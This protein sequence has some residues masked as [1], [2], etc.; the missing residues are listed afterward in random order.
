MKFTT[1]LIIVSL[2]LCLW[3]ITGCT[4]DEEKYPN[5]VYILAD[6]M[7]Y[8]DV[9]GLNPESKI[10]TPNLDLLAQ[11]GITF[12]DA[13]SG[14]AVCTPT[15]YGILT[16]R[17]CWRTPLKSSVLWPWDG[18]LIEAD[19]L[20]VGGFL[21]Q[22]GYTT[23]CIGKWHLGWDW[24]TL[25]G[26]EMNEDI[27]FGK[28]DREVRG[29]IANSIDFSGE[30][31]NGPVTRGFDYYFGDDVPNF[32]PY[33][34]IENNRTM[35]I[36]SLEKP[37]SMYGNPGI[38]VDGWK[39]E[40]V[41]PAL[42]R[43]VV[44][45]IKDEA[46]E[47]LFKRNRN[48][49]FFLYFPLTAPHTPIAPAADFQGKS[50]AGA[51]GDFV[52]QIDWTVKEI[53]EALDQIGQKQNTLVIFT[54]DN[55]S[56]GRSGENMVGEYN[57]VREFGHNPSY[58][59]RGTKTDTWEG[60]HRVPFIARWPGLISSG[61]TCSETICLTDLM[62]TCASIANKE[63]PDEAG[64]DS[65]SI[66]PLLKGTEYYGN[67][68]NATVHHSNNGNFAIRK[69]N[70]KLILC[71]GSGGISQPRNRNEDE[72]GRPPYQLYNID[73]DPGER[74]N[75][76][77]L[78]PGKVIELRQLLNEYIVIGR[79]TPGKIQNN[80]TEVSLFTRT[81][82]VNQKAPNASDD[83]NGSES[84]P[85]LTIQA[86]AE[87][88]GPGDTVLVR[89]GIY[90][91][92]IAPSF[93]GTKEL[94]VVYMAAPGEKVSIRGSEEVS[95]W[96]K[97]KPNVWK[98]ELDT[99]FFE[100]YN[101][102][103]INI[104][105]EWL[106]RGKEHH[107]GDVYLDGEA[108]LEKFSVDSLLSNPNTWY[109]DTELIVDERKIFP[110]AKIK[111]YAN[112]GGED[113]NSHLTEINARATAFFPEIS[114]LKYI[115]IDGFDIRH[116]APQW[117]DIYKLEQGAVGMRY[118][119]GWVIQNCT[120]AYSRNIGISM[121]VSDEV[122][123]PTKEEGGLLEGGSNIPDY[124]SIGH[125]II[126]NNTISRCGQ[127]GI[128]GCY[129]AVASLIEGNTISEINYRNEWFGT[130]QAAIKILFPIDVVI[131]NNRI[132]G[133]PGLRNGTK[134]IW[135]D[136][137]SQNTRVS[138]NMITDFEFKG[139]DGLKLEVNFG[140]VIVDN[141]IIIR[142]HV[143]EE[144][145][146]S[147]FAHNLF[148]DGSFTF[149]KSPERIVPYFKA[150]S[151]VRT[152][153]GGTSLENVTFYNNIF[154]GA[155]TKKLFRKAV[156]DTDIITD[157]NLFLKGS[158]LVC[159]MG[160]DNDSISIRIPFSGQALKRNYPLITSDLIGK[161]PFADM[162]MEHQDGSPLNITHD[163]QGKPIDSSN[164]KPGPFQNLV[165]GANNFV[166]SFDGKLPFLTTT[167]KKLDNIF[168][169]QN[170][171]WGFEN[172][173]KTALQK[174]DLMKAIGFDGL[175]G[176][177]YKDFFELKDALVF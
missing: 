31:K 37:D 72:A 154:T 149:R 82:V 64:E 123:F 33:C 12:T 175:E 114:G 9:S 129:G 92:E 108:L 60:G 145:N 71:S 177:G 23:A 169:C 125:H 172:Q 34:F 95:G 81:I 70:W 76:Y 53:L 3:V 41:M 91:E 57:S 157:F 148:V 117:G 39:L 163:I 103:A 127:N 144:G 132:C 164:V 156:S 35:G 158:S 54:S 83:N 170:T 135:L 155:H 44:E 84:F 168:Y 124:S 5:I 126:R 166:L 46:G 13:H 36:P 134:G 109:V 85:L 111:I 6:D 151:T 58:I 32:P 73:S 11:E 119:Y 78:Y 7:G 140:P 143:M 52:Q 63:L 102:F 80:S 62:A 79:S 25:D 131:R 139:T 55:G 162:L 45:Y 28:W 59:F 150:H 136:W 110:E 93:G 15:R 40:E 115:T 112:F 24:S 16:G 74:T 20:T 176:A 97:H 51:Y 19:R 87:I 122:H 8:G 133:T 4:S 10:S 113:P 66:L 147:V 42:T 116:T 174:A 165:S 56:P 90:R 26:S 105:G 49:P 48:K 99:C 152:G 153:K 21:K 1:K 14:S 18:P 89:E 138:G 96:E 50:E 65:Y 47:G 137:G 104:E 75:L 106:F 98:L 30:I 67:F 86:A 107:L 17:Y 68:R 101:P 2:L 161:I 130:N 29:R 167:Q 118:G 27:P 22:H 121:G 38:M 94:P 43:K 88:A 69:D 173:P 128:Y 77:K 142:S 120:I 100:G 141:N 61:T 171:L 146:G 159:D 160:Y